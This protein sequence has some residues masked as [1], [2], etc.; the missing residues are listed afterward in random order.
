MPASLN[1]ISNLTIE[2]A[3]TYVNAVKA[4]KESLNE[5]VSLDIE[6][7]LN[8]DGQMDIICTNPPNKVAKAVIESNINN[9]FDDIYVED[10]FDEYFDAIGMFKPDSLYK[11]F[12]NSFSELVRNIKL[13]Y[14]ALA[15]SGFE[16]KLKAKLGIKG[17]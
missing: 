17:V 14:P 3:L 8:S 16:D 5:R 1:E 15:Y 4:L 13:T 6:F 10:I 12:Q 9:M 11:Q 7:S 2:K